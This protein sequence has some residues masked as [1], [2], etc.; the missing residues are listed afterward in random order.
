MPPLVKCIPIEDMSHTSWVSF[1]L[2]SCRRRGENGPP[3][4]SHAT[5]PIVLAELRR[6]FPL[7]KDR[8]GDRQYVGGLTPCFVGP[9][10]GTCDGG[11]G[12]WGGSRE[13]SGNPDW[14]LISRSKVGYGL[15]GEA[16]VDSP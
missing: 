8:A 4:S 2:A 11:L 9:L 10:V 1:S 14:T 7:L 3:L 5:L 15:S 12:D 13:R 6:L 16:G